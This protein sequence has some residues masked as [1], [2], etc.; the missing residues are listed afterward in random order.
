MIEVWA[1]RQGRVRLRRPGQED[2][3]LHAAAV[4]PFAFIPEPAALP[5]VLDA[6]EVAPVPEPLS[7]Q[8]ADAEPA[9]VAEAVAVGVGTDAVASGAVLI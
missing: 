4:L 1:P 3:A 2:V 5:T 9:P 8:P 7:P 6:V